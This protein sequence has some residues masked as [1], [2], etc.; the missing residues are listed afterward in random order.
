MLNMEYQKK[1]IV[2]MGSIVEDYDS[3]SEGY[4]T[5]SH[6]KR[7][8]D[9]WQLSDF[10]KQLLSEDGII[11]MP[12]VLEHNKHSGVFITDYRHALVFEWDRY[13]NFINEVLH[14]EGKDIRISW[15]E[16]DLTVNVSR[17][18]ADYTIHTS[19]SEITPSVQNVKLYKGMNSVL[20]KLFKLLDINLINHKVTVQ[21]LEKYKEKC[22]EL[23]QK[24]SNNIHENG[25]LYLSA[26]PEDILTASL[27]EYG[28][29]SCFCPDEEN[30]VVPYLYLRDRHAIIAY[31]V[32]NSASHVRVGDMTFHRKMWRMWLHF[33]EEGN[34]T[35]SETHYPF[36][37]PIMKRAVIDLIKQ[38]I[39]NA[40]FHEDYIPNNEAAGYFSCISDLLQIQPHIGERET[41]TSKGAICYE[42]GEDIS[43]QEFIALVKVERGEYYCESCDTYVNELYSH[44]YG[45]R[46]FHCCD[47]CFES[48][49]YCEVSDRFVDWD[50]GSWG[51]AIHPRENYVELVEVDYLKSEMGTTNYKIIKMEEDY[52]DRPIYLNI[53]DMSEVKDDQHLH[54]LLYQAMEL[55]NNEK[56]VASYYVKLENYCVWKGS[57]YNMSYGYLKIMFRRTIKRFIKLNELSLRYLNN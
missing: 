38:H 56:Q 46:E 40:Q 43:E 18:R 31:F 37:D 35:F 22:T 9:E 47:Y 25:I 5:T 32:S 44:W 30:S 33:T 8:A 6:A 16:I 52:H 2:G 49:S 41:V 14:R 34:I 17:V 42:T 45:G 7:L 28:W 4:I 19:K 53:L 51:V 54:D 15:L 50:P 57:C 21:F 29:R 11:S 1:V 13:E 48:L 24:L 27:S 36:T 26:L 23:E 10:Q 39:P 55:F 12:F 20:R 3:Q